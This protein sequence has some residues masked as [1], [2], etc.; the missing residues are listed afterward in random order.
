VTLLKII[1]RYKE[2]LER[3][4]DIRNHRVIGGLKDFDKESRVPTIYQDRD[5]PGNH[6]TG[7][8]DLQA[9]GNPT[10]TARSVRLKLRENSTYRNST[11]NTSSTY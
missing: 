8:G 11:Q 1:I 4:R 9:L 2:E 7:S 5:K 10:A 3:S 6:E